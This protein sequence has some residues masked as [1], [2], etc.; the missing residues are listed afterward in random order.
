MKIL[1]FDRKN[2][3][4]VI[5]KVVKKTVY[6][7]MKW[8]WPCGVGYYGVCKAWEVL[9][10]DEYIEF[11]VE[12]VDEYLEIG[13]PPFMVNSVSMGHTMLTLYEATNDEKYLDIANRKAEYL[14]NDA[15]RFGEN[16]FQ[17]TVSS[18]ND[19]PEQAWADTLFM[20]AYFLLRMGVKFNIEE[21]VNDALNQYYW[22]EELLQ[23]N[24]TN[25]YY[26]GW[27]NVNKNH[28]SGVFWARGNAWATLTMA[29]AL[30]LLV[31]QNPYFMN[32]DC[33]LRDQLSA[34]V[35]LQLDNGLWPTVLTD[36]SSY[37]EVSASAGIATGLLIYAHPEHGNPLYL[38][39]VNKALKGILENIDE[40][41]SVRSV[42]AG[43]AIMENEATYNKIGK[44][45]IQGWGQGLTLAFLSEVLKFDDSL[46]K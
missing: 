9:K 37:G 1:E 6:M 39:Y 24:K 33:S 20:A 7:D 22:H 35:R 11:L 45:R 8:N 23:D 38:K 34:L 26:H 15:L 10:K 30:K 28:M 29:E 43:T 36:S 25:L 44:K 19:F 27:D 2:I 17:H 32:I 14:K 46:K 12:W 31:P 40:D 5:D 18:K 41:G 4:N 13:L 16:I 3:E 42:S 21:Y